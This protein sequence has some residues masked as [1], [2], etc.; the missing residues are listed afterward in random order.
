MKSRSRFAIAALFVTAGGIFFWWQNVAPEEHRI[1]FVLTGIEIPGDGTK[2]TYESIDSMLCSV[3][4]EQGVEVATIRHKKP[5][6]VTNVV[7]L[8]L[9][10]ATYWL[11]CRL[12][13]EESDSKIRTVPVLKERFLGGGNITVHL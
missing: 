12:R 8:E 13:F 3:L 1:T 9:P 10:K 4:D 2:L 11:N 7:S 6:A 5:G